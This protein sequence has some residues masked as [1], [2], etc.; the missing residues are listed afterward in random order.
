MLEL[1]ENFCI[2]SGI[3]SL[4]VVLPILRFI[5]KIRFPQ[6][7]SKREYLSMVAICSDHDVDPSS[8]AYK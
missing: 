7:E 6:K 8:I 3:M 5:S 1:L 4:F 2:K